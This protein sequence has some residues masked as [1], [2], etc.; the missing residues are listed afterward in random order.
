MARPSSL[1]APAHELVLKALRKCGE[2]M[3]AYTL[4]DALK[5][6]GIKS[7][8]I[9]YRALE[10]LMEQGSVHKIQT[11]N[12]YV[13]CDCTADHKHTLSVL[14][15]C[16]SCDTTEELHD[17]AII[18]QLSALKKHGIPLRDNAV[19]ELPITCGACV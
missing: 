4:L 19:I 1:S 10:I 7:P 14:T 18:H 13:A 5:K 11:L 2:P 8:P 3:T 15:V 16:A 12:A 17:H 9:V 6:T